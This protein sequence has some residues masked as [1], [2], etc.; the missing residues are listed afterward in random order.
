MYPFL[1]PLGA[2]FRQFPAR[3]LDSYTAVEPNPYLHP[4]LKERAAEGG[5]PCIDIVVGVFPLLLFVSNFCVCMRV[6]CAC[7]RACA[8]ACACIPYFLRCHVEQSK[9]ALEHLQSLPSDSLDGVVSTYFLCRAPEHEQ[10]L[11]EVL[12]VLKPGGRMFFVEPAKHG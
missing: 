6:R 9:T 1:G 8:C 10:T 7:A 3:G 4:T 2:N 11:K 12:R 5:Y